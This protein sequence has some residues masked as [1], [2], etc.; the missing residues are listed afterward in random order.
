M[1]NI[2]RLRRMGI[3]SSLLVRRKGIIE[4]SGR[5]PSLSNRVPLPSD[6]VAPQSSQAAEGIKRVK[7][8]DPRLPDRFYD[9][10]SWSFALAS[11]HRP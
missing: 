9:V 11:P 5:A 7:S 6:V 2:A 8:R 1:E 10:P 3:I 4:P